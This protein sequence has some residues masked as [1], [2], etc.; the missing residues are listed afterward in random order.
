[1]V[2]RPVQDAAPPAPTL[3][4]CTTLFRSRTEADPSKRAELYK[5]VSKISRTEATRVPLLFADRPSAVSARVAGYTGDSVS[6]GTV[7]LRPDRKSTRL[8]SSHLSSSYSVLCLN[9]K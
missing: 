2:H 4:P 3:F 9:N 7:W 6:F 5:Q 1:D 8:N